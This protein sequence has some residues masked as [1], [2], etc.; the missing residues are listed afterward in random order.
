M[1]V[2]SYIS[3]P[4][5]KERIDDKIDETEAQEAERIR[6][7]PPPKAPVKKKAAPAKKKVAGGGGTDFM[8][9]LLI[10]RGKLE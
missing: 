2:T 5:L 3:N 10:R 9:E 6:N 1:L 4:Q 8:A 7:P